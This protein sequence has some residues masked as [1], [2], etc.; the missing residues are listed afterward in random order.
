MDFDTDDTFLYTY[1][2]LNSGRT[3]E[4]R[5]LS[6]AQV[7][8]EEDRPETLRAESAPDRSEVKHNAKQR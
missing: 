5:S 4:R 1:S 7:E 6:L 3:I 8:D 2:Q